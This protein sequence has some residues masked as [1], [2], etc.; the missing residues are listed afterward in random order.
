MRQTLLGVA[1]T[2]AALGAYSHA[3]GHQVAT[4]TPE[5]DATGISFT[6]SGVQ[7]TFTLPEGFVEPTGRDKASTDMAAA[8]DDRNMTHFTAIPRDEAGREEGFASWAILKTP[9]A[10]IGKR[11]PPRAKWVA[12]FKAGIKRGD[13]AKILKDAS[14]LAAAKYE[15]VFGAD[16]RIG[17]HMEPVDADD[18]AGYMCGTMVIEVTGNRRVVACAAATTV[19]RDSVFFYYRYAPYSTLADVAALLARVKPEIRGFALQN[20]D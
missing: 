12:D 2:V 17:A 8:R 14:Q 15:D 18:Y 19:V 9:R 11:I 7:Y 4:R 20:P 13:L 3:V 1:Y 5:G 10:S 16:A 6:L